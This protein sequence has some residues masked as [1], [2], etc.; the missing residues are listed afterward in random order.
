MR[1]TRLTGIWHTLQ[2]K[3]LKKQTA[4]EFLKNRHIPFHKTFTLSFY[5]IPPLYSGFM[6]LCETKARKN[7]ITKN[8]HKYDRLYP[9]K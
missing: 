5:Y 8:I 9:R 1:Q 2:R 7:N 3:R 4:N 6:K